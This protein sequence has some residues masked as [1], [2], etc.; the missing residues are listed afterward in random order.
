MP[1][2]TRLPAELIRISDS[3]QTIVKRKPDMML[4]LLALFGLGVILT[5]LLP[6]TASDTVAEPASALQTG[7]IYDPDTVAVYN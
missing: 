6:M 3:G 7:V 2:M 4:I 1:E 5:L